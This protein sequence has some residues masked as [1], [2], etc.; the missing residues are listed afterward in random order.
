MSVLFPEPEGPT[1][2][3]QS[4]LLSLKLTSCR[5]CFSGLYEKFTFSNSTLPSH[6]FGSRGFSGFATSIFM[7]KYSKIL[8][9]KAMDLIQST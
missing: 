7:S 2:A 8:V 6:S 9:N 5:I 3:M 1:I 4:P